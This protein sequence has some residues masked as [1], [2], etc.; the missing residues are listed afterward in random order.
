MPK[1]IFVQESNFIAKLSDPSD[2]DLVRQL[3]KSGDIEKT[4][5]HTEVFKLVDYQNRVKKRRV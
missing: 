2:I 3:L 4:S 1:F 5:K